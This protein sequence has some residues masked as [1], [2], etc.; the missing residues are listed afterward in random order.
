MHRLSRYMEDLERKLLTYY[1]RS[2]RSTYELAEKTGLHQ[3]SIMRRLKRY[4]ITLGK[5]EAEG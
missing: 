2:C 3:S 5:P 1:A 4:G